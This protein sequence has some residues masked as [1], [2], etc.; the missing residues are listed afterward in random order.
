VTVL[1]RSEQELGIEGLDTE[2]Y[3][4]LTQLSVKNCIASRQ[5]DKNFILNKI[6]DIDTFDVY[7]QTIIFGEHGILAQQFSGFGMLDMA[8]SVAFRVASTKSCAEL[9]P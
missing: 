9:T 4:K 8:V 1:L 5:E 6:P 2:L 7:L 3:V